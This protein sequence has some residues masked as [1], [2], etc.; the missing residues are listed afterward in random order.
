MR[1][2]SPILVVIF[3]SA[4]AIGCSKEPEPTPAAIDGEFRTLL[5]TLDPE[6]PG[7]SV[8]RLTDF[9]TQYAKYD[10][11]P[12]IEAEIA[13]LRAAAD[14]RYHQ[15][16]ELAREGDFARAEAM[17]DDL[18][19]HLPETSDGAS[20]KKHLGFDFY[21]G[22]AQWLM[23]RERWDESG[24]VARLLLER[25][26]SRT[27]KEQVEAILDAAGHVGAAKSQ[28]ER[29]QARAACRQLM[30]LLET[31]YVDEGQYPAR[32]SLADVE[33]WD[34]YGSRSIL[35]ALSTIQGYQRTDRSYSFTAVSA[36]KQH[37]IRIVDGAIED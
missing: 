7:A 15:A 4:T 31:K 14:G 5:E 22:K 8:T 2:L 13:R 20:A 6:R 17:L 29:A 35:R 24:E 12:E 28:A 1:I 25:D 19:T 30:I 16:R 32:L 34:P 9:M 21:L 10:I 33:D 18:A 27:Q 37:R 26:L 36:G 23:V 11:V 3:L